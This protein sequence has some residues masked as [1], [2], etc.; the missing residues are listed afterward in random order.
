[1]SR[2]RKNTLSNIDKSHLTVNE[3]TQI[4]KNNM[5]KETET[6]T[7]KEEELRKS[8]LERIQNT[9]NKK[10]EVSTPVSVDV[11]STRKVVNPLYAEILEYSKN[12]NVSMSQAIKLAQKL[13]SI[14]ESGEWDELTRAAF[15]Q[16]SNVSDF[17]NDYRNARK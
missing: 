6:I 2:K 1:M 3:T 5:I 4:E 8:D 15:A 13:L 7:P 12:Y 11:I 14:K 16:V 9:I 17:L 10:F